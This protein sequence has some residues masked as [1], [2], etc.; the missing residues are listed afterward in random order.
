MFIGHYGPS[1][2]AKAI[3]PA[4]PLGLLFLTTQVSDVLWATL[5]LVG[6]ER[7][8]IVPAPPG[9]AYPFTYFQPYSHSLAGA[10]VQS[11]AVY[12][13]SRAL[14]PGTGPARHRAALLTGGTT[15]S[16]WVLD[17]IVH[18]RSL[19]LWDNAPKVGL[20]LYNR[21][22]A[23]YALEG[24]FLLGGLGWYLRSTRLASGV[25]G[26]A[27]M[28]LLAGVMLLLDGFATFGPPQRD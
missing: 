7:T 13:A 3:D 10:L 19:P 2:A 6:A 1:Y 27:G 28:G 4:L 26:R 15:L 5:N 20:G 8:E 21:P 12:A 17:A 23:A 14:L 9:T 16:H 11:A 24:L 25:A 18:R 22:Y